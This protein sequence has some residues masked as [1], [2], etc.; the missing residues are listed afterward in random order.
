MKKYLQKF[1]TLG[2][3][4]LVAAVIW[5]SVANIWDKWNIGLAIAG[6][7]LLLI[8]LAAN[9]RQILSTLGKRSTKH[10]S[11]YVV[12]VFLVV[13]VVVGLNYIGQKHPKRFD[14]TAIGRYTL[15]P[16]T[17]Q[18]LGKLKN[19]VEIKAF[20]PGGEHAPLKELLTEYRTESSR[21]RHEFIDPDK[22][23]ESA[24]S[25]NVTAYG[26][27]Q[28]PFTGSSTK[29]GTVIVLYG[30][31][32]EKI[33][34]RSEE[35][36]EEDLTNAIIRAGRTEAKR[37]YFV[38]GH[39]EKDPSDAEQSGYSEMKKKL[40]EQGY[41]VDMLNLAS[42][43]KVPDDAKVIILAGPT[44]APFPQ[45]LQLINDFLNQ[46]NGGLLLMADPPPA[47]SFEAFLKEWG[48]K[49]DNDFVLDISG[50]G[51]FY[52]AGP[53]I[54]VVLKYESHKITDRLKNTMTFFPLVRSLQP[55]ATA[56]NGV[57]VDV[58]FKSNENSWG[59][60]TLG[61]KSASYE[62]K[63]DLKGPLPLAVAIT[64]EIKPSSD[65][66]PALTSRMVVVGTS[67]FSI[68]SYFQ[69]QGNGNLM[70]NMV[71][72]LSEDE[73]LISIRPKD[74]QDRRMLLTQSQISMLRLYAIILLPGLALVAGI[75]VVV[76]RRRR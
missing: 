43:G 50:V 8:G 16:Q 21:I 23:P 47:P 48:L 60:T 67:N 74:P 2:L 26:V 68:N 27:S 25:Y 19:N 58:L 36:K 4:L 35:V 45:E 15:A 1:D 6:A 22:H 63:T 56:P 33:E 61:T 69:E 12:S 49:A 75:I 20:F 7:A 64:K 28:N 30:D 40:E 71:S 14:M 51:R 41:K 42:Q 29:F 73:D 55:E 3:I 37:V 66:S 17:V 34:K 38:Q 72:W 9:Y 24:K 57:K 11:N 13:A 5:Y 18:V 46:K 10:A 31:K 53:S 65:K 32:I 62:P 76:K 59:E 44:T 52:G 54:P 70:M 39:G